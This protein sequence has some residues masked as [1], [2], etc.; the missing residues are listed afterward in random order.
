MRRGVHLLA[1][2]AVAGWIV[3]GVAPDGWGWLGM[4]IIG[5]CGAASA[6]LNV[7]DAAR[8]RRP[9]TPVAADTMTE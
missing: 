3:F 4:V 9:S 2:A 1:A 8:Q 7:R 5:A 6:W